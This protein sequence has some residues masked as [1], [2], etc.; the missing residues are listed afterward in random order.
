MIA[1]VAD[2]EQLLGSDRAAL[3]Q[4]IVD[5]QCLGSGQMVVAGE[6]LRMCWRVVGVPFDADDLVGENCGAVPQPRFA[7]IGRR[8]FSGNCYPA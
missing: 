8:H 7:L 5:R 4:R 6:L 1:T 3:H 2:D